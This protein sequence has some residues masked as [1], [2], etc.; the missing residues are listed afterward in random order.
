VELSGV[1]ELQVLLEGVSLPA[2]R[3]SLVEYALREGARSD[4]IGL[5][6]G[7]PDCRYGS[8]D[9]V[10]EELA[11]VQ[12]SRD[13]NEPQSPH[14]ESGDPPGREAYTQKHPRSGAVRR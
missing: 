12:P 13:R 8:I 9:E 3:S 10:G 7:L 4:Q 14:E 11:S 5:L 1:A 2:E 6:Q